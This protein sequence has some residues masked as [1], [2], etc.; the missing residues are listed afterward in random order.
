MW[1]WEA[2][3]GTTGKIQRISYLMNMETSSYMLYVMMKDGTTKKM[4]ACKDSDFPN[5][6]DRVALY[7]AREQRE[8]IPLAVPMVKQEK[9][10]TLM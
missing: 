8:E 10:C 5:L 1:V 6:N 2:P 9:G 3:S 7:E 4:S